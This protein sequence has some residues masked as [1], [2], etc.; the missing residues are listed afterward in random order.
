[1]SYR[2]VNNTQ[3]GAT[4]SNG[5]PT[6]MR[7]ASQ[8]ADVD[9]TN[10]ADT[11]NLTNSLGGGHKLNDYYR[12]GAEAAGVAGP[13]SLQTEIM[14][15][16]LNGHGYGSNDLLWGAYGFASWF[17]TGESRNYDSKKGTFGREKP[18]KNFSLKNGGWGAWELAARYDALDM[19]TQNVH[20]GRLQEGT[21]AMNWYLN[22]HVRMMFDYSHV[23]VNSNS[24]TAANNTQGSSLFASN[25]QHP[26]IFMIR[27]Q[28]D[29]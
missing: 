2:T 18:N 3:N 4:Q 6:S 9:R 24:A 1:L 5:A 26:D 25:G 20:G 11:G 27:T 28:L 14:G 21:I 7:F 19:N 17:I 16:K 13:F 29:W 12:L 8:I 10:F 22:P 23:F 15:T